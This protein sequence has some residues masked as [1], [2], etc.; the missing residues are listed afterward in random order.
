MPISSHLAKKHHLLHFSPLK[1]KFEKLTFFLSNF[2]TKF[3][4]KIFEM[5]FV[6]LPRGKYTFCSKFEFISCLFVNCLLARKPN[7]VQNLDNTE[8]GKVW[9]MSIKDSWEVFM[10]KL[11]YGSENLTILRT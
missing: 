9:E 11:F 5:I 1:S 7:Y 3:L 8:V 2:S 6:G 4:V 10:T